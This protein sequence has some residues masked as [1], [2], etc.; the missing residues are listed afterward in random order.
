MPEAVAA[1]IVSQIFS[2]ILLLAALAIL[3]WIVV[4]FV[5]AVW[6]GLKVEQNTINKKL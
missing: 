3:G 1:Q 6:A 4:S 2:V 5:V